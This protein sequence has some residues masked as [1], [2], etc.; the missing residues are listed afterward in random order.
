[1]LITAAMMLI[2]IVAGYL[3]GSMALLADGWHMAT[4]VGALGLTSLAYTLARKYA[5]H[6]A[7]AFGT[8]KVTTLAAFTNA[9]GLGLVAVLMMVEATRRLLTPHSVDFTASLPVAFVG[10]VVNVVSV[11]LLHDHALD[12][13]GRDHHSE[14]GRDHNHRAALL[15]VMADTLTSALAIVALLAGRYLDWVFLDATMGVVGGLVI[16]KWSVALCR[17]SAAEL[18]DFV[19]SGDLPAR[20]RAALEAVEGVRVLDLHVWSLG[21]GATSCVVTVE[22]QNPADPAFYRTQLQSLGLSH[23]TL[24]VQPLERQGRSA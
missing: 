17:A 4:H 7:F 24:E 1:V 11:A 6:H 20:V 21:H 3:S 22:C 9:L 12:G 13:H 8:G 15:H 10:L 2:E 18:L 23:V 16:V 14:H 5:R 19:P